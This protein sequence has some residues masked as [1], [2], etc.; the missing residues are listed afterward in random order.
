MNYTSVEQS[1]K[2][3]E[4]GLNPDS[5]DM[6]TEMFDENG[7]MVSLVIGGRGDK[8]KRN[9]GTPI[10]STG[11][12]IELLP[13]SIGAYNRVI[14]MNF[15]NYETSYSCLIEFANHNLMDNLIEAIEWAIKNK[16]IKYDD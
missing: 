12:L 3:L 10:W 2:L 13:K 8:S 15:V 16:Y 14:W 9:Y 4:L 5:A 11:R 6:H 1:K 7:D